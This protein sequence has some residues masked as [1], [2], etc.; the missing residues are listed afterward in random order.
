MCRVA[1][2]AMSCR[3]LMRGVEHQ[4]L[5]AVAVEAGRWGVSRLVMPCT[6]TDRNTLIRE[7]LA[8]VDAWCSC[9][10]HPGAPYTWEAGRMAGL[11]WKDTYGEDGGNVQTEAPPTAP[12]VGEGGVRNLS[13]FLARA[14]ELGNVPPGVGAALERARAARKAIASG[15]Q[16]PI[17]TVLGCVQATLGRR[18]A[19]G[20]FK[21]R[22]SE[23]GMDSVAA[24]RFAALLSRALPEGRVQPALVFSDPKLRAVLDAARGNTP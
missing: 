9:S 24:A 6:V 10:A 18:P 1:L 20:V 23:L 11:Q 2:L 13:P 12:P 16:D 17:E 21:M 19:K 15:G 22:L 7:F 4:L 3:V 8:R 5:R 14:A